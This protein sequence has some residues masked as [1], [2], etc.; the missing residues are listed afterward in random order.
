[1]KKRKTDFKKL[2]LSK[3]TIANANNVNGGHGE[4]ATAVGCAPTAQGCIT[5]E[6][7]DCGVT[8]YFTACNGRVQCELIDPN[9]GF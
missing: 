1:M 9:G 6:T 7:P 4:G 2:S 8:L 3:Q 5:I